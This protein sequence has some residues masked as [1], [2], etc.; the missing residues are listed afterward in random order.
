MNIALAWL[1]TQ[2]NSRNTFRCWYVDSFPDLESCLRDPNRYIDQK[3]IDWVI[4]RDSKDP[5]EY[6]IDMHGGN[7]CNLVSELD[8]S[9]HRMRNT[10]INYTESYLDCTNQTEDILINKSMLINAQEN[11]DKKNNVLDETNN[12]LDE[13]RSEVET[14]EDLKRVD[15]KKSQRQSRRTRNLKCKKSNTSVSKTRH[16]F[17]IQKVPKSSYSSQICMPLREIQDARYRMCAHEESSILSTS[18]GESQTKSSSKF[19]FNDAVFRCTVN[20]C[21]KLYRRRSHLQ[22]HMRR[23]TGERPFPCTWESCK[24][25][26]SRSDELVRH[27][28]SHSGDKPFNCT[29]CSKRFARSDHLKKHLRV[30]QKALVG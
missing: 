29:T 18:S 6:L 14:F 27:M 2:V 26:F 30:H 9:A 11:V 15:T 23:H 8:V 13:N 10:D 17:L 1:R 20:G 12:N 7:I 25:K 22:S 3:F 4:D 28:R 19:A 21:G 24:W 5:P 16:Q